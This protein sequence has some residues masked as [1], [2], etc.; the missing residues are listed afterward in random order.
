MAGDA[1]FLFF[2]I[3]LAACLLTTSRA[4]PTEVKVGLIIDADSPVGKIARTTI[5]MALEDFYAAVANSTARVK[6]LQHDSGGDVVA[7]ASAGMLHLSMHGSS[8]LDAHF[9]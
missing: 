9:L 8:S 5:P 7:A 2:L 6:I 3:G 1:R 4:Q